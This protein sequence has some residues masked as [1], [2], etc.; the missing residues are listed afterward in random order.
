[1][2]TKLLI[3]IVFL[4]PTVGLNF[5]RL[6]P[7]NRLTKSIIQRDIRQKLP[8]RGSGRAQSWNR[9]ALLILLPH[10]L[11]SP[12]RQGDN[13]SDYPILRSEVY[14]LS[15]LTI[16]YL[17][18]SDLVYLL[19]CLNR[20]HLSVLKSADRDHQ[21]TVFSTI[22]IVAYCSDRNLRSLMPDIC[23]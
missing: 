20:L 22:R 12:D 8:D 7:K 14:I 11:S 16:D 5:L 9:K 13:T 15:Y 2:D 10:R 4:V 21:H 23:P 19:W 3:K 1:M 18:P 6:M 17:C